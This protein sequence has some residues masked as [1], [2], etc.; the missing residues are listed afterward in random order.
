MTGNYVWAGICA[1]H[2]CSL[3]SIAL[4]AVDLH[5]KFPCWLSRIH[6]FVFPKFSGVVFIQYFWE[7][8]SSSSLPARR[9][10]LT[11][12]WEALNMHGNFPYRSISFIGYCLYG[13][14]QFYKAFVSNIWTESDSK[15]LNDELAFPGFSR[16]LGSWRGLVSDTS[17][18]STYTSWAL[19]IFTVKTNDDTPCT[20][21]TWNTEQVLAHFLLQ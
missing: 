18:L 1:W 7:L 17:A 15:W 2:I 21:N 11:W 12:R 20:G 9:N 10:L 3:V 14:Y 16:G 5:S 19:E 8:L 4:Y 13:K 6:K